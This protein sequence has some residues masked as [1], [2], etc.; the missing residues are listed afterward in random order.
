[1]LDFKSNNEIMEA[2]VREIGVGV[3]RGGGGKGLRGSN[4]TQKLRGGSEVICNIQLNTVQLK[5]KLK[6]KKEI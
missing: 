2:E 1:M 3:A 4:P 6:I 5:S